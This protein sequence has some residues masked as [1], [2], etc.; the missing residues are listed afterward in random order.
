MRIPRLPNLPP[1]LPE[2]CVAVCVT[3][4]LAWLM[5]K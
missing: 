1:W 2:A 3:V 5:L 4:G